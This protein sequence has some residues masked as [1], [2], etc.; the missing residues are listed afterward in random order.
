MKI[1]D[2]YLCKN[3]LGP[4]VLTFFVA[5]FVLL[6]QFLW[7]W[8]DELVGK[9][10]G[11]G[12]LLKLLFYASITLSSM[13]FPL[14]V[15]LASLMTFG[16]MGERSEIVALKSAGVSTRRMMMP[17]AIV[18][19][20]IGCLAFEVSNDVIPRA[21]VKLKMLLFDIQEQKPALNI[22]EGVFYTD[23][24]NYAIRVGKKMPDG[25]T[26]KDILIYDHS[27]HQGNINV[28][29]AEKGTMVVTPDKRYLLFTL[30]NGSS[31]DE[32]S[33]TRGNY[34]A[35]THYP[36]MRATFDKQYKRFDMSDF[37]AQNVDASFYENHSSALSIKQ[38]NEQI[39]TAKYHIKT[40]NQ[41]TANVFFHC[42]YFFNAVVQDNDRVDSASTEGIRPLEEYNDDFRARVLQLAEHGIRNTTYAL[43]YTFQDVHYRTHQLWNYQIELYRK[44]TLAVACLLFFFVGAPLG[45]IIRKGGIGIP[46]VITVVFFTFY[47]A[48]SI[49][50]EK[51][52]KSSPLPVWFGMWLSS[53]VLLPICVFLTYH[54]TT[55]SS[56]LS[57]DT[58]AKFI[59]N[60]KNL[61]IFKKRNENTTTVS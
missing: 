51:L 33:V 5:L 55:D 4:F 1:T 12:V 9:G 48:I 27:K 37:T 26:I 18:S 35:R 42:L 15:L 54:A 32:S 25:V 31:W 38:L 8:V 58:Y 43:N 57:P 59:E 16:N 40:Q 19:I 13:A 24:D 21:S 10:L 17:L 11:M 45:S 52:S 7:K 34:D 28:T 50:G 61:K 49:I 41:S 29:S 36:L 3:F 14:A 60:L 39:D 44:F 46:L 53:F 56:V 23:I 30:Y 2:R 47:F 22:T 6:M 20:L